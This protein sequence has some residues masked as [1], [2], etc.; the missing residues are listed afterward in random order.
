MNVTDPKKRRREGSH[1]HMYQQCVAKTMATGMQ[2]SPRVRRV[3]A[4]YKQG[5]CKAR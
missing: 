4:K 3:A 2:W 1:Q 5:Y